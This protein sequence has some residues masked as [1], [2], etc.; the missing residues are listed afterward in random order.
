MK[1]ALLIGLSFA[2]LLLITGC[3][4]SAEPA[5]EDDNSMPPEM[6]EEEETNA[7]DSEDPQN[8]PVLVV[9]YEQEGQLMVA[10]GYNAPQPLTSGPND[11]IP[12]ISADGSQVLFQRSLA[13]G[14]AD[15]PR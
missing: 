4:D 7:A 13:P 14:P 12:V 8:Q 10:F 6:L 1:K 15:L 9:V 5:I 2:L 3:S 11:S